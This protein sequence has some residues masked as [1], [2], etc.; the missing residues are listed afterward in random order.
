[1][2]LKKNIL[3]SVSDVIRDV[4]ESDTS[5]Y[6]ENAVPKGTYVRSSKWDLLGIITDGFYNEVDNQQVIIYT[7]LYLPN[8][9]PG[10]YYK[11]ILDQNSHMKST[12][13]IDNEIEFDLTFFLMVPP[14]DIEDM[15]IYSTQGSF[16]DLL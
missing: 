2:S 10:S 15:T 11:N 5:P 3:D 13:F 1:M 8:T 9:K 7:V 6:P 4:F 16:G 12:M 14:A